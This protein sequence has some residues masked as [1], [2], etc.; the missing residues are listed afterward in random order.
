MHT[1]DHVNTE[2]AAVCKARREAS[3]ETNPS[4]TLVLELQP[5]EL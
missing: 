3:G 4:D 5:P 1:G 2:K